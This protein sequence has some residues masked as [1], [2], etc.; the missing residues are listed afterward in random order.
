MFDDYEVILK[1]AFLF[2]K[3][4][5]NTL[6]KIT[7]LFKQERH[8]KGTVLIRKRERADQIF[9][10]KKGEVEVKFRYTNYDSQVNTPN[11]GG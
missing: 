11:L 5:P 10:I 1:N 4:N 6:Q 8:I 7:Y 9:F 3:L 2:K